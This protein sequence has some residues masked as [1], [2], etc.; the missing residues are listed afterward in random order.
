MVA[1]MQGGMGIV[2]M[3]DGSSKQTTAGA[4]RRHRPRRPPAEGTVRQVLLRRAGRAHGPVHVRR[5]QGRP[6][7]PP[8]DDAAQRVHQVDRSRTS[9][10][11]IRRRRRTAR[12]TSSTCIT[13]S[14]RSGSGPVPSTYIRARIEQYDLDKVVHFGRIW[15]L[16]YDGVKRGARRDR[17]RQDRSAHEQRDA[18]PARGAPRRIP[19]AGGVTRRSN[20]SCSSRT[21]PSCRR[22]RRWSKTSP[23]LLGRFHALWTLEGLGALDAAL[24]RQLME[25]PEPRMRDPGDSCQRD[26]LQGRRPVVR[27]GLQR[28]DEGPERRRRRS[29]QC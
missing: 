23:N 17:S 16:V 11:S 18:G 3:P 15:R 26:A 22:C 6:D 9:V 8:H 27:R 4:G 5:E 21:S 25:D 28:V 10:L 13:G 12:S 20:C 29:R 7:V 2:R 1:D 14:F 19:M 24:A